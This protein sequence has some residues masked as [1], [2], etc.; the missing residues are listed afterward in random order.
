MLSI[1]AVRV[2][3]NA[4]FR[5]RPCRALEAR[6][7]LGACGKSAF[8][9]RCFQSGG[10]GAARALR[11]GEAGSCP[12][13][14]RHFGT[15]RPAAGAGYVGCASDGP[16]YA[17]GQ[18][19]SQRR[20]SPFASTG[21]GHGKCA[22]A[23]RWELYRPA[24]CGAVGQSVKYPA[25]GSPIFDCLQIGWPAVVFASIRNHHAQFRL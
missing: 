22:R 24:G 20:G 13:F 21:R 2:E 25:S 7:S 18:C 12:P 11:D 19:F 9:R 14:E 6:R 3:P 23:A 8:V 1:N 10:F 5:T 16:L 4:A 17:D 15:V